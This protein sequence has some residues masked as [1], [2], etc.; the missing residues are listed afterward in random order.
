MRNYDDQKSKFCN[1]KTAIKE[2]EN[3]AKNGTYKSLIMSYNS[4]GIMQK[5]EI[6][7]VLSKYG[8]AKLVEFDYLRFKSNSNGDSKHK[9]YVKEQLYILKK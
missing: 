9:K 8:K 7:D 4:E 3:I 2:L 6:I 5:K 1:A